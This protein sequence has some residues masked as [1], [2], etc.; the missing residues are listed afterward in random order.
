MMGD[1]AL[2][3]PIVSLQF[4]LIW[5]VSVGVVIAMETLAFA[6][7]TPHLYIASKNG[8]L[9]KVQ[10]RLRHGEDPDQGI[11]EDPNEEG[12][13]PLSVAAVNGHKKIVE[14]LL[15]SHAKVDHTNDGFTPLYLASF[16][17]HDDIVNLL[18]D[19][20][21]KIDQQNTFNRLT[22]LCA[23]ISH[24]NL[25]TVE[26][27]LKRGANPNLVVGESFTAL[28]L[29]AFNG[30]VEIVKTLLAWG[31]KTDLT[32]D[33]GDTALR[34]AWGNEHD[35]TVDLLLDSGRLNLELELKVA[36]IKQEDVLVKKLKKKLH[37]Q[38]EQAC[39][40]KVI[41]TGHGIT[42]LAKPLGDLGDDKLHD[43]ALACFDKVEAK[44]ALLK[45]R[46]LAKKKLSQLERRKSKSSD[47]EIQQARRELINLEADTTCPTCME[48]LFKPGKMVSLS[49]Q[50]LYCKT[51]YEKML[52]EPKEISNDD[53][54]ERELNCP[55]C[56]EGFCGK[57]V[58]EVESR[59]PVFRDQNCTSG[60]NH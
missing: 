22:P 26:L 3:G 50:H 33:L 57:T 15:E 1:P 43:L 58:L 54:S 2:R 53:E 56:R 7:S 30:Y 14:A 23:A 28:M 45:H 31:A 10:E 16:M 4:L 51:C 38:A 42:I 59:N 17:G 49:C 34:G 25:E 11:P 60:H 39:T 41:K 13:T 48:C 19:R 8:D 9:E 46:R 6:I 32:N 5:T 40:R 12:T 27:L 52:T 20:G 55:L 36:Q 35:S 29:A 18:L 37:K 47:A 24:R 21:A 44:A